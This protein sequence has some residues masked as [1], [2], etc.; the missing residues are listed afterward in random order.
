MNTIAWTTT[1]ASMPEA[2]PGIV[3]LEQDEQ[4]T[5]VEELA[6]SDSQPDG[7]AVTENG[8]LDGDAADDLLAELGW[9]RTGEWIGSGGQ[10][11]AQVER[12]VG[13]ESAP[14][15]VTHQPQT[16]GPNESGPISSVELSPEL[17]AA[18]D[19]AGVDLDQVE[20]HSDDTITIATADGVIAIGED[21][22]WITA[23]L[24]GES[25][26]MIYEGTALADLAAA[27]ARYAG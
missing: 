7:W 16:A 1:S 14:R 18:F 19:A 9:R 26:N 13:A 22:G 12:A 4:D 15:L 3:V 11:A 17:V 5:A 6:R 23:N 10:W 27:V 20:T 25:D 2:D 8:G 21:D 24:A